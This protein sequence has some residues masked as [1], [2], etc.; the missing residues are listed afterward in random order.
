MAMVA[1]AAAVISMVVLAVAVLGGR[2]GGGG[3]AFN[4]GGGVVA[5][6]GCVRHTRFLALIRHGSKRGVI[7]TI[8]DPARGTVQGDVAFGR[9]PTI[10][11]GAAAANGP[12]VMSTATPLGRDASAIERCWDRFFPIAPR[13]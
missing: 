7:E 4:G 12:Y 5:F 9:A 1:T 11:G 3:S 10:L 6:N 8:E 13:A 2:G